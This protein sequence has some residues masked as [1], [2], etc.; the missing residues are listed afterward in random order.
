M[1]DKETQVVSEADERLLSYV[2]LIAHVIQQRVA[3]PAPPAPKTSFWAGFREPAVLAALVTVLIGGVAA[4]LIT[5]IIQW[6]SGVREFEQNRAARDREF[7]QAWL[8]SRGDQALVSYKEYLDQ[9][10]TLIRR[11]YSLIG[12]CTSASDRLAGLTRDIWRQEFSSHQ[13]LANDQQMIGI[14]QN[15]NQARI[16][17][18]AESGEIGLLMGYYHP[19]QPN[20]MLSWSKVEKSVTGYLDCAQSWYDEHID[21]KLAPKDDEVRNACRPKE[22]ELTSGLGELTTSLESARRYAWTGWDSPQELKKLLQGTSLRSL[23]EAS[24]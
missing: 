21:Q 12:T 16:K 17:W 1:A 2:A 23:A 11:A 4:T 14:R 8:K 20:V 24:E 10:Q 19:S 7:E 5:G 6:R 13:R 22:D 15:F 3:P 18:Q 9:E